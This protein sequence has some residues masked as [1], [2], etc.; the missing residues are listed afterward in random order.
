MAIAPP[1]STPT[2][3]LPPPPQPVGQYRAWVKT[4]NLIFISGQFPLVNGT[5]RYPGKLGVNVSDADGYAAARLAG[6]NVLAQLDEAT[7]GFE[8][9]EQILR[10]E[11]HI[12][13]GSDWHQ[14]AQILNGA[15]DLLAEVLGDRAGHT[16]TAFGHSA[17]PLNAPVE[18]VVTAAIRTPS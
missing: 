5:M 12:Q 11:G 17:L 9:L 4:G 1:S 10:L 7:Q 6:L 14:H 3:T 8:Q 15:S 18:L 13:C 16:R 2:L